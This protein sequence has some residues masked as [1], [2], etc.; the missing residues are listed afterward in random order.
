MADGGDGGGPPTTNSTTRTSD[1]AAAD[2]DDWL[3]VRRGGGNEHSLAPGIIFRHHR[4]FHVLVVP[5]FGESVIDTEYLA[6][7][8]GGAA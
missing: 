2:D 6:R 7:D 3:L 5:V 1:A 8:V 4:H